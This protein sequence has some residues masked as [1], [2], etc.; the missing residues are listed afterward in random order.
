MSVVVTWLGHSTAVLD[1]ATPGGMVRLVTDPLLHRH[2]GLLRRRG[3]RPATEAWQGADAVLLSHLH[4]DHAELRSLRLLGDVPVLTA[5][6]NARWLRAK[7]L[8]GVGLDDGWHDV[9]PWVD[10]RLA[11]AV[12]GHRPMPHR[13][14]AATGHVVRARVDGRP[15]TV[16][17]VGD[18]ER[19]GGIGHV[20]ELAGGH[21]DVAL[22]PVHGWGPR[23]SG[24]HLGPVQAAQVCAEV[25]VRVAVPVHWGTLHAPG[26]RHLPPGWMDHAGAAFAA[27]AHRR[28]PSTRVV[29]LEPG[30]SAEVVDAAA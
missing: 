20:R 19:F 12:H 22:V 9:A 26:T 25:G 17:A 21:V 7:G 5:P 6:A 23:L 27:A 11:P 24:G 28:A 29:L 10:V 16:W 3:E 1:L 30:G 14:N 15:V 2:A 18:T 4:H 13:P 8:R